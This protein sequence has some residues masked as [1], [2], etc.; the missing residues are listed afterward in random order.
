MSR[1]LI[2]ALVLAVGPGCT[3]LQ[4]QR[5]TV[6]QAATLEEVYQ[7]QVLDNLAKFV[8]NPNALPHF[9]FPNQG[10]ADVTD[11]G[12]AQPAEAWKPPAYT[13]AGASTQLQAERIVRLN[14]TM[15]P[16]RDPQKLALM[17]CAYQR[18]IAGTV[19]GP[20]PAC[21]ECDARFAEFYEG[22]G[23]GRDAAAL[24]F[25]PGW[26]RHGCEKDCLKECGCGPVG[27]YCGVCV[28]VPPEGRAELTKLTLAILDYAVNDPKPPAVATKT[29]EVYLVG[30]TPTT[31]DK[32]TTK[33]VAVVPASQDLTMAA[34]TL[35]GGNEGKGAPPQLSV[36]LPG[37]SAFGSDRP[38]LLPLQQQ[39]ELLS[40]P[41]SR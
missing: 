41:R 21:L 5:S 16:I 18:A 8:Q 26:F 14:W 11:S 20:L 36:P 24:T 2:S 33:I 32:A 37:G 15:V 31:L 23:A 4:L 39:L 7:Q 3:H 1:V 28:W 38:S 17:Q 35:L 13:F 29:V 27:H 25:R 6:A 10:S 9:A 30:N 12:Y 19:A 40:P 34:K 22:R